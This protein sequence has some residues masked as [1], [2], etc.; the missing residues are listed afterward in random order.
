MLRLLIINRT[1]RFAER[2]QQHE[3]NGLTSVL[4]NESVTEDLVLSGPASDVRNQFP[5]AAMKTDGL[6]PELLYPE[7]LIS[8]SVTAEKTQKRGTCTA[9]Q[10]TKLHLSFDP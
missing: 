7:D 9:G 8:S 3:D 6:T 5:A 4:M 10:I 1:T 2:T